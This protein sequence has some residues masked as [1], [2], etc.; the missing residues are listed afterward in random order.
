MSFTLHED[1]FSLI[2]V[3]QAKINGK[4][5]RRAARTSATEQL[6]ERVGDWLSVRVG[7]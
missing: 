7:D 4:F 3:L 5:V 6:V 1:A 2:F